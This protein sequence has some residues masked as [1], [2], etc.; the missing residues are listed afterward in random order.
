MAAQKYEGLEGVKFLVDLRADLLRLQKSEP[1]LVILDQELKDLLAKI[2]VKEKAFREKLEAATDPDEKQEMKRALDRQES[3]A[4]FHEE[5]RKAAEE[6]YREFKAMRSAME[7][8][9]AEE[10]MNYLRKQYDDE[11]K[12]RQASGVGS[13]QASAET[14]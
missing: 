5:R 12:K 2:E 11:R 14:E 6:R 9:T 3:T 13:P 4:N 8:M 10:R 7:S 1:K